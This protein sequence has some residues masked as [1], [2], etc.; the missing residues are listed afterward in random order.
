MVMIMKIVILKI[1]QIFNVLIKTFTRKTDLLTFEISINIYDL[2]INYNMLYN[3]DVF[4]G[5]IS[6]WFLFSCKMKF[7]SLNFEW[8]SYNIFC[9]IFNFMGVATKILCRIFFNIR[10]YSHTFPLNINFLFFLNISEYLSKSPNI[11]Q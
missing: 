9:I 2:L 8:Y 7:Y 10:D 3:N 4:K 11:S 6:S 5:F 1:C